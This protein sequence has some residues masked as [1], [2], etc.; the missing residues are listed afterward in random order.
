MTKLELAELL[1]NT[2]W[3]DDGSKEKQAEAV[4]AAMAA[5]AAQAQPAVKKAAKG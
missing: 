4:L 3:T 5:E 1:R 2:S